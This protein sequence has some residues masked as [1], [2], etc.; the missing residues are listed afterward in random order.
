MKKL[1][2]LIIF[3]ILFA[4][5][6][7][8]QE[9]YGEFLQNAKAAAENGRIKEFNLNFRYFVTAMDRD[10]ITPEILTKENFDLFS[11]CIFWGISSD[12]IKAEDLK[13]DIVP[14]LEY[15]IEN[16]PS[17]MGVLGNLYKLGMGTSQDFEKARDW[18]EKGAERDDAWSTWQ[19]G[20]MYATSLG[21]VRDEEKAKTYYQ[22]AAE[23][24]NTTAMVFLA[25]SYKNGLGYKKDIPRAIELYKKAIEKASNLDKGVYISI[26]A[27]TYQN[28]VK[29]K[30]E[31]K[32]WYNQAKEQYQHQA[33]KGNMFD[34]FHLGAMYEY[35]NGVKQDTQKAK[36]WYRKSCEAGF[37][38]ACQSYETLK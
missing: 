6:H 2:L 19:L 22:Q 23:L 37:E 12:W 17:N 35:G 33:E 11:E 20:L 13:T 16:H 1:L 30:K 27:D 18:F 31:A 32:Y 14:F 34:M 5:L 38:T 7:A 4:S 24:G 29:N 28:K 21:G 15:D 10:K 36:E 3:T 25:S 9:E 8:Q 26:L